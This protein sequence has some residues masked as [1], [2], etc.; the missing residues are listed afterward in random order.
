MTDYSKLIQ[1]D[2]GQTATEI[3]I[4]SKEGFGDWFARQPGPVRAAATA[5]KL[6][7]NAGDFAILHIPA[8][9]TG[10]PR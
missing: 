5:Q 7:G 6:D 1:P 10:R 9:T 2:S 3:E 4:V 8:A